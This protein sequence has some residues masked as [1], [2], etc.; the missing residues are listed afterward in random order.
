V[1]I[2]GSEGLK[3]NDQLEVCHRHQ[4]PKVNKSLWGMDFPS[5]GR[6]EEGL[7]QPQAMLSKEELQSLKRQGEGKF[8]YLPPWNSA[9]SM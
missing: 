9:H 1:K 8:V 7:K 2:T 5:Q 3:E 6:V 4:N